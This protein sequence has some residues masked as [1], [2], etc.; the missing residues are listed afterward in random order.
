MIPA[1]LFFLIIYSLAGALAKQRFLRGSVHAI[2]VIGVGEM[3][4]EVH[5]PVRCMQVNIGML[6][7]VEHICFHR[8]IM[9]HIEESEAVAGMEWFFEIPVSDIVAGKTGVAAETV[10]YRVRYIR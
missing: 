9:V 5:P 4:E 2:F 1:K 7:A 3:T 8:G 10:S 6:H